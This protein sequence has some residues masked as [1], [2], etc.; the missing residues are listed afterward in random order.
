MTESMPL[1]TK[2]VPV[3]SSLAAVSVTIVV[4]GFILPNGCHSH[5]KLILRLERNSFSRRRGIPLG[6]GKIMTNCRPEFLDYVQVVST[7]HRREKWRPLQIIPVSYN[8][9]GFSRFLRNASAHVRRQLVCRPNGLISSCKFGIF[10]NWSSLA[11]TFR[12]T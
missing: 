4:E 10:A 3:M 7:R 5:G 1:S 2:I 6:L 8:P 12:G 9:P 11:L